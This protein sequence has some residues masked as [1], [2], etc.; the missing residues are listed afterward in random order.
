MKIMAMV[1]F[2]LGMT[3]LSSCSKSK[4]KLIVGEWKLNSFTVITNEGSY[5]LDVDLLWEMIG[6]EEEE[7]EDIVFKFTDGK[8]YM[9]DEGGLSYTVNGDQLTIE[10]NEGASQQYEVMTIS[11]LTEKAM[12][13]EKTKI[14]EETQVAMT[15][16]LHFK[17]VK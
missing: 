11:E 7:Q 13:L 15:V 17:K 4:D 10:V 2:V 14:D 16:A 3:A 12:T 5:D 6:V 8:V 1:L 9:N